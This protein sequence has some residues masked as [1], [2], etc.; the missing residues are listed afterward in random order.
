MS[1][2]NTPLWDQTQAGTTD[3]A[4]PFPELYIRNYLN[5]EG[6]LTSEKTPLQRRIDMYAVQP[7]QIQ[8]ILSR[9]PGQE[10]IPIVYLNGAPQTPTTNYTINSRT[11]TFP[12]DILNVG[13][14]VKVI[15]YA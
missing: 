2:Y 4:P 11:V 5:D 6:I 15:Y 12:S 1:T 3:N 13:D 7:G 10:Y 8:F 14:K 9:V